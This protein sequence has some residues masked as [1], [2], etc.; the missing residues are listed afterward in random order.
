MKACAQ[1][2][3]Q[4]MQVFMFDETFEIFTYICAS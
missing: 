3:L 4:Q 1:Q 2:T